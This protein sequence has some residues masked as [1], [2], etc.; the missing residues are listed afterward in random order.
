MPLPGAEGRVTLSLEYLGDRGSVVRDVAQLVGKS[1]LE[2]GHCAHTDRML[3]PAGEQR[4]PG[5]RTERSY[6]EVRELKTVS[7][8]LVNVWSIDF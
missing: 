6:V 4:G 2:V 8:Q 1:G 3:R 5:R 7:R